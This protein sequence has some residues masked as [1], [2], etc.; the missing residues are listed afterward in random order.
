MK[1]WQV[2]RVTKDLLTLPEKTDSDIV[3]KDVNSVFSLSF[4][5]LSCLS[6]AS[7]H[8]LPLFLSWSHYVD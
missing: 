2:P 7:C 3:L 1:G 6:D 8:H 4:L 5:Y